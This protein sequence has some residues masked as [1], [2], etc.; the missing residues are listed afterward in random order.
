MQIEPKT[1]GEREHA[2][3]TKPE[4]EEPCSPNDIEF[5]G[6]FD[7]DSPRSLVFFLLLLLGFHVIGTIHLILHHLQNSSTVAAPGKEKER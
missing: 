7:N 6:C 4:S 1:Q 2:K 3:M 5:G